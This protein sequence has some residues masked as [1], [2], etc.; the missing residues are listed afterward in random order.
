MSSSDKSLRRADSWIRFCNSF[1]KSRSA[2]AQA[3]LPEMVRNYFGMLEPDDRLIYY[4]TARDLYSFRGNVVDAGTFVRGTTIALICGLIA[5]RALKC[6]NN[7]EAR[8]HA[9]DL[10][11]YNFSTCEQLDWLLRFLGEEPLSEGESYF[12]YFK[13]LMG[14]FMGF[15]QPHIGDIREARYDE[16]RP[17]EVLGVDICKSL[18]LTHATFATFFPRL[19][20]GAHVL[21][22]DFINP[23][24]PWL[25]VTMGYFAEHFEVIHETDLGTTVLYRLMAPIHDNQML[26]LRDLLMRRRHE[27]MSYF[28]RSVADISRRRSR[29][30]L[31]TTR[32][33]CLAYA[34]GADAAKAYAATVRRSLQ[35]PETTFLDRVLEYIAHGMPSHGVCPSRPRSAIR[36]EP[37]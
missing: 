11:Q 12:A 26:A 32:T 4:R 21:H 15:V 36:Q 30:W 14:P 37:S 31:E 22:Q 7:A 20:A 1:A 23:W 3:E 9:Y 34:Q 5:N 19:M 16:A 10:F 6:T 35:H 25:Q 18:E 27:W 28:D 13:R 8:V 29:R 33:L 24:Q 2:S 17:I